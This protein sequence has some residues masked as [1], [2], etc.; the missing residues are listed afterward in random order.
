[1][2]RY[3]KVLGTVPVMFRCNKVFSII[4]VMFKYSK[5]LSTVTGMFRYSMVLSTISGMF[6]YNKVLSKLP[7]MLRYSQILSTIFGMFRY[8]S[9]RAFARLR[10]VPVHPTLQSLAY[11]GMGSTW[12]T[13]PGVSKCIKKQLTLQ[14][15]ACELTHDSNI[16]C[17]LS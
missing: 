11:P 7:V 15:S 1:M 5:V 13:V 17:T 16:W 4:A 6:M 14:N 2:L 3:S 12:I 8:I 9:T 10:S